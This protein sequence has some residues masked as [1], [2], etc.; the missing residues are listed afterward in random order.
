MIAKV[1]DIKSNCD[2][3]SSKTCRNDFFVIIVQANT[4]AH[5][6]SYPMCTK[7]LFVQRR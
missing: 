3:S 4:G 2:A 5:P 7:G 1:Q 6:T